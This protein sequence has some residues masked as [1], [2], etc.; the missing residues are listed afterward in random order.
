MRGRETEGGYWRSVLEVHLECSA[1]EM[2]GNAFILYPCLAK[3]PV[4]EEAIVRVIV[5]SWG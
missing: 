1:P 4:I 2:V 5:V 3:A